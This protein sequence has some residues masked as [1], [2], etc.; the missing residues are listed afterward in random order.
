MCVNIGFFLRYFC[1]VCILLVI[2]NVILVSRVIF[3]ICSVGSLGLGLFV[4]D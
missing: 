1:W 2:K 4:N 3:L